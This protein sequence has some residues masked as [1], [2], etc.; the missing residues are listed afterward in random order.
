MRGRA[1]SSTVLAILIFGIALGVASYILTTKV[2]ISSLSDLMTSQVAD[3][4]AQILESGSKSTKLPE[5][6]AVE[7]SRPVYMQVRSSQG[8]VLAETPGIAVN[9]NICL[10]PTPTD[11][12][13][14]QI[15]LDFGRGPQQFLATSSKVTI[16]GQPAKICAA[17]STATVHIL[18]RNFI[19][20]FLI[21]LPLVLI[22]VAFSVRAALNRALGSVEYLRKQAEGMSGTQDGELEVQHTRDEVERLGI[23]LNDLL[24][25]IHDQSQATQ[26]FIADAGHEL[27]NP[28]ATL[29]V[30]LEF[31]EDSDQ[32]L[33]LG[34]LER[35][36]ALV[37][38]LLVLAKVDAHELAQSEYLDL[39]PLLKASVNAHQIRHPEITIDIESSSAIVLGD[40][41]ELRSVLD[42]LISNACRHAHSRVEVTL[43]ASDQICEISV[44]DDGTGLAP[45]DCE[46]VFERF[47]RLDEARNRDEGGSGLGLAIASAIATSMQGSITASP[48]PGG[49][50][51]VALPLAQK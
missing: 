12:V 51:S 40:S 21:G 13:V 23:T 39:E 43:Q 49:R 27:R 41:R 15:S 48:G 9:R 16:D 17:T 14:S 3:T 34:E 29:R 28:L 19:I 2:A 24:R 37:Q 30:L 46:R 45:E 35:L 50:F 18:Q 11:S 6:E 25:R 47:V 31:S 4:Q 5:L 38:D 22:G 20:F 10:S 1:M 42:N 7:A 32:T 36:D 33:A 26:Q 44:H 8:D